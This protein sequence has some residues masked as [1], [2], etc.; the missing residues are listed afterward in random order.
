MSITSTGGKP[1]PNGRFRPHRIGSFRTSALALGLLAAASL[2]TLSYAQT[3][4]NSPAPP[5]PGRLV[6]T[7]GGHRLHLWCTGDGPAPTVILL[8]G[9]NGSSA[10]WGLV[11]PA[12]AAGARVCSYDR[13]DLAWSDKGPDPRGV[14]VSAD[15]L[16][17]VL[18]R[19]AVPGPYVLA[20]VSLGGTIARVFAHKYPDDVAGVLLIDAPL[21][22]TA[23]VPEDILS[24]LDTRA[25]V[26]TPPANL[27]PEMQAV[28]TWVRDL[29][30]TEKPPPTLRDGRREYPTT[31]MTFTSPIWLETSDLGEPQRALAATMAGTKVPLGDKPLFVI[32]AGRLDARTTGSSYIDALRAHVANQ[33]SAAGLSRN[34]Q[35][36]VARASFHAVM[37]YEPQLVTSA[38][39]QVLTSARTGERLKPLR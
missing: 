6:A 19:G 32:S 14:G 22:G 37:F 1:M 13:A 21:N 4:G 38:I 26:E 36:A 33:A 9:A 15:E 18:R 3:P 27:P 7:D 16:H 31:G 17:Q 8:T 24:S 12:V 23:P 34:S 20:G 35:F 10:D 2:P 11:Q 5:M 28:L 29:A 25:E 39:L 30:R